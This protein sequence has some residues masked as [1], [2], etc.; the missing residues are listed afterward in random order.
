MTKYGAGLRSG[1]YL[2]PSLDRIAAITRSVR[3]E[4]ESQSAA[5]S[6]AC[7]TRSYAGGFVYGGVRLG[8]SM[9]REG[10]T[11]GGVGLGP[12]FACIHVGVRT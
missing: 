2:T 12:D 10:V 1:S 3:A 5:H 8:I 6:L 9:I 11:E 4:P 7:S